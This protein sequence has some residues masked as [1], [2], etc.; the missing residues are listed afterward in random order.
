MVDLSRS[1]STARVSLELTVERHLDMCPTSGDCRR[2]D[3]G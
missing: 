1:A 2:S 3:L